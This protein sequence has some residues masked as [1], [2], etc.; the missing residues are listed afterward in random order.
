[1]IGRITKLLSGVYT[2]ETPEAAYLCRA[3]GSFR[4]Q[5]IAPVPGDEVEILSLPDHT[6]R[7]DRI[8]PRR[9]YLIRPNVANVDILCYISSYG[10]PVPSAFTIDKMLVIAQTRGIEPILVFNKTDC[11]DAQADALAALY[12]GLGLSVFETSALTGAGCEALL[13]VLAGKTTVFAGNSGVGKS[14]LLN[15]LFPFLQLET[16]EISQKLG[17]GRHTTRHIEFYPINGGLIGDTP[18]FGALELDDYQIERKALS[19]CFPEFDP[20]TADCAFVDCTHINERICGVR[21]AVEAGHIAQS[22][23]DSYRQIHDFL[24]EEEA[25]WLRKNA[26]P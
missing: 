7:I 4:K 12:R 3:R 9:N 14:S 13:T 16:G 24:K 19:G 1:M 22:R 2:V 8:L 11:E 15:R 26:R 25:P 23:Y 21:A 6:G 18:G 10:K 17:R 20:F 5:G